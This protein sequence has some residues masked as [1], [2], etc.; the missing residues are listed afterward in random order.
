MSVT[1]LTVLKT[2]LDDLSYAELMQLVLSECRNCN[3]TG[4]QACGTMKCAECDGHGRF[5]TRFGGAMSFVVLFVE[6]CKDGK[7][8]SM[9]DRK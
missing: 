7:I 1:T 4:Y 6:E 2:L 5:L 3:S 9:V 8:P